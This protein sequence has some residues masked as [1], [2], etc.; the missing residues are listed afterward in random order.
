MHHYICC[1]NEELPV[2]LGEYICRSKLF[3]FV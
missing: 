1:I 2:T 3:D